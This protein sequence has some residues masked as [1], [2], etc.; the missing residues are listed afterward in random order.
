MTYGIPN[1]AEASFADQS[2]PYATDFAVI[3]DAFKRRGV[4]SGCTVSTLGT[5]SVNVA[6]GTIEYN[7][8]SVSVS[9]GNVG[10]LGAAA[11]NPRFD[12]VVVNSSGTKSVVAGVAAANPLFPAMPAN[13]VLLAAC[14]VPTGTA[15]IDAT[16]II[17]KRIMLDLFEGHDAHDHSTA[18]GSVVLSDISNVDNTAPT[19]GEVLAWNGSA[20]APSA[21]AGGGVS[22]HGALTGLADDDH[23]QYFNTT[24][25]DAHDH[26]TALATANIGDLAN[27]SSAVPSSGQALSWTGSEW[28]P[29]TIS[30]GGG[31]TDHGALT[32]LGDDDHAQYLNTTRHNALDHSTALGTAVISD[33]SDVSVTAPS[34]GQVLAWSGSAWAP[35]TNPAGVTDHGALTGLA[36]DDHTQ[37]LTTSRHSTLDHSAVAEATIR[38][39]NL[40]DVILTGAS[41]GQI[42]GFNGAIWENVTSPAGVTDHGLLSGLGDDDHTNYLTAGRHATTDHSTALD[43]AVLADLNNVAA[44]APSTGQA[45]IWNGSTWTPGSA[46]HGLLGGLADDD[47]TQ[48][49]NTTRHDAHDHS[50][51][52][53][54]AVL[55]DLSNVLATTPTSGDV[56]QWNGSN[57]GPAAVAGGGSQTPWT[58]NVDAD[59]FTLT[60]VGAIAIGST[61]LTTGTAEFSITPST[62]TGTGSMQI[63][64][65]GT[66]TLSGTGQTVV[67]GMKFGAFNLATATTISQ[68][69]GLRFDSL[70]SGPTNPIG[71]AWGVFGEI[72]AST[73]TTITLGVGVRGSI[74]A[75]LGTTTTGV[76]VDA[77]STA[78]IGSVGTMIGLRVTSLGV[79]TTK[80]GMQV[81]DYQS[82]HHGK[83]TLGSTSDP[84]YGL[85]L[86]GTAADRGVIA[87]AEASATPANPAA[88]A[89][90]LLYMKADKL[91]IGYL[92]GATMRYKYLDLTGTGVTWVHTTTAP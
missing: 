53:G 63:I 31:A 22:D 88:S 60:D 75:G 30:G 5:M 40:L 33:L 77:V 25:H 50:T 62:Y 87:L 52:L 28:A 92:D 14:Y 43:T 46:D 4:R 61:A 90:A 36:D 76:A 91:V 32:G 35:T 16:R 23:T 58:A 56:L 57:W 2:K 86:K 27:V 84:T 7:G 66:L 12:L 19:T 44:T 89:Q 51:A 78:S 48:Y 13:S 41:A 42:L 3:A 81:G 18:M 65:V 68:F 37:Y 6:S 10:P 1:E 67:H 85:D 38:I 39:N 80:Y 21:S 11:G 82:Y 55:A 47:H 26:T 29:A 34:S 20:W 45:L 74:N 54:T 17:D 72:K 49:L 73:D 83:M 69:Y 9:A 64:D 8:A 79:G 59:T 15:S 24:R 70:I 71:T